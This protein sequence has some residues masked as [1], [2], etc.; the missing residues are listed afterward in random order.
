MSFL[1][2]AHK[3]AHLSAV[4]KLRLVSF[5]SELKPFNHPKWTEC[6]S[7][8]TGTSTIAIVVLTVGTSA[9]LAVAHHQGWGG[10]G[11]FQQ[12]IAISDS[13]KAQVEFI[14]W[15]TGP[16][17]R[18]IAETRALIGWAKRANR[19]GKA[20]SSWHNARSRDLSCR[21]LL[22]K[23]AKCVVK[24]RPCQ[25]KEKLEFNVLF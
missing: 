22:R 8:M 7:V 5:H 21:V 19:H 10:F 17:S 15:S 20:Y 2:K 3:K 12:G 18:A 25:S 6:G 24:G 11:E 16:G 13:C 1:E 4:G 14:G 9:S 23:T